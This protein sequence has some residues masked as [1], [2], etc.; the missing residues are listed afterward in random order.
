M[1]GVNR[2]SGRAWKVAEKTQGEAKA[3]KTGERGWHS[4]S[5]CANYLDLRGVP[6]LARSARKG[7]TRLLG[8][9]RIRTGG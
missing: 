7:G 9:G 6:L 4:A 1:A 8:R 3:A 5:P 2:V